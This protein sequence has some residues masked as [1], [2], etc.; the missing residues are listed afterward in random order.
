MIDLY[1]ALHRYLSFKMS[2]ESFSRLCRI[3]GAGPRQF[4]AQHIPLLAGYISD[5]Y[6][7]G[8][9]YKAMILQLK[10]FSVYVTVDDKTVTIQI[11]GY[12]NIRPLDRRRYHE[13]KIKLPTRSRRSF[14]SHE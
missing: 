1:K 11:D 7:N 6:Y 4:I 2:N 8:E 5:M 12:T 3:V 14:I 9:D 10:E 13:T